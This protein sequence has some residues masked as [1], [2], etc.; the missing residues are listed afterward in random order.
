ML[1]GCLYWSF[2]DTVADGAEEVA[3]DGGRV[4]EELGVAAHSSL[5]CLT[6]SGGAVASGA[7]GL[8]VLRARD[9]MLPGGPEIDRA[10]RDWARNTNGCSARRVPD[11]RPAARR[12]PL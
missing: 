1:A 11:V 8:P 10:A 12:R 3:A 9:R 4:D 7:V 6:L 5:C 2:E